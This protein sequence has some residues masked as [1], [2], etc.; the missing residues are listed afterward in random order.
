MFRRA[1]LVCLVRFHGSTYRY[2][3]EPRGLKLACGHV[4]NYVGRSPYYR[5]SDN[6]A[7]CSKE[8]P[9][10]VAEEVRSREILLHAAGLCD[11]CGLCFASEP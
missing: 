5:K 2:P 6:C 8:I 1:A 7:A 4:I 3:W 11:G 9:R 10:R